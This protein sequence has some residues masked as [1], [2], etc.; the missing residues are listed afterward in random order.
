MIKI[1]LVGIAVAVVSFSAGIWTRE[2]L[3]ERPAL[4]AGNLST[5]S[6]SE[7]HRNLKSDDVP[8][9]YMKGDSYY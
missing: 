3:F 6:P 5:I 2:T 4:A 8:V 9:Q 1:T 7:M